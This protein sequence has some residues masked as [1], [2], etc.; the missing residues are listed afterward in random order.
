MADHQP[1][2]GFIEFD[3]DLVLS[4]ILTPRLMDHL[5]KVI[6][7]FGI[8][9]YAIISTSQDVLAGTLEPMK[10]HYKLPL[11][12]E[13]EPIG[14]LS[15]PEIDPCLAQGIHKFLV[16]MIQSEWRYHMASD[17]HLKAIKADYEA[18]K[19][20][21][22]LLQQSEA[23]YKE[24]SESL[25]LK[26]KEQIS[27]IESTQRKLYQAEKLASVGQLA[28]GMAHEINNPIGFIHSNL[29]TANDYLSELLEWYKQLPDNVK[30]AAI[31]DILEDFPLLL[32]E[33]LEGSDRV[34]QIVADLKAYSNIDYTETRRINLR[35]TIERVVR[36][37]STQ[38]NKQIDVQMDI[39]DDLHLTCF[40]GYI[41]QMLLNVLS[42]AANAIAEAGK[43]TIRGFRQEQ[44]MIICIADD[45]RGMTESIISR[46]FD[47]FFTTQ[48]VGKGVGLGLTVARDIARKHNG[49]IELTSELERGT[50]VTITLQ[51]I[52]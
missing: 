6:K 46:A 44:Q 27:T 43:I 12:P 1:T 16:M 28:A 18:L 14:F 51:D 8:G 40:S 38:H 45:G 11:A 24:L 26:V 50:R 22:Q 5:D 29:K 52:N 3:G 34:R 4:D 17:I 19:E 35:D 48:D 39:D 31:Q 36:I 10:S 2:M 42:N 41:N 23:Q 13:L 47:P 21:H 37:F 15:L 33:C 30:Q 20:K 9:E 49:D 32:N 7:E 25:D